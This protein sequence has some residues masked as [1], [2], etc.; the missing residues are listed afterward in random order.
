MKR[1]LARFLLPVW[2]FF[3]LFFAVLW[4]ES[5]KKVKCFSDLETP[6]EMT[7]KEGNTRLSRIFLFGFYSFWYP[8]ALLATYLGEDVENCKNI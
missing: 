1:I 2:L 6:I 4:L 7:K 5:G 3:N 8:S